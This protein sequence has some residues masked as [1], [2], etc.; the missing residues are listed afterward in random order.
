MKKAGQRRDPVG[1]AARAVT[2]IAYPATSVKTTVMGVQYPVARSRSH[3][4]VHIKDAQ[5]GRSHFCFGCD[6][7]MVIKRGD[8]RSPHF[9]HKAGFVQ[10]EGDNTLHEAAKAFIRQGFL[11]AVATGG[12]YQ[13]GYPCKGCE[14]PISVNVAIEGASIDSEKTVVEGTRSDLVIFQPDGSPRIIIEIVVT[15]DLESDT[16]QRYKAANY[17]VVTVQPSWD[18]LLAFCQSAIGSRILNVKG[19]TRYCDDCRAAQAPKTQQRRM[20]VLVSDDAAKTTVASTA[21]D[22]MKI[23]SYARAK[24]EGRKT[25]WLKPKRE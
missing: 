7:E 18:T 12:E 23:P 6:R 24:A 5:R 22:L 17:P 3:E 25:R 15:H 8:V 4:A 2:P 19:D 10:C 13:V 16:K 1:P 9:A 11:H 21:L 14:T 20:S